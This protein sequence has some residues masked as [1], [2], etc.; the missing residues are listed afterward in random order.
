MPTLAATR[1]PSSR[2]SGPA[3]QLGDQAGA[4]VDGVQVAV[5]VGRED[6]E[7]VAADAGDGVHRAAATA[8][9]WSATRRSTVSPAA[10]PWVSLTCLKRSRSTK[11]T[12]VHRPE[13][14]DVRQGLVDAVDE[15]RPVRQAGQRVVRRLLGERGLRVLQVG[16]PLGLGLAEPGDLAV[17]GLLGAEVGEREA[18]EL[19]AVDLERR[20]S[21]PGRERP[22]RRRRRGRA[23]RWRRA[24]PGRGARPSAIGSAAGHERRQRRPDDRLPRARQQLG[25]PSVGVQDEPARRER[26]RPVAHVLDEHPVRPV[27]GRQRE[28]APAASAVGDDEGVDLAGAD[29]AQRVLRLGHPDQRLGRRRPSIAALAIRRPSASGSASPV[30]RRTRRR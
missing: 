30:R 18:G 12:A 14:F 8:T 9:S 15:Q 11:R 16:H 3:A 19:V 6:D 26:R 13:R 29:R 24:R 2:R 1:S 20:A 28:H 27:G 22:R 17:L 5:D 4:D 21:R 23:R 25:Q 7:L 10:C